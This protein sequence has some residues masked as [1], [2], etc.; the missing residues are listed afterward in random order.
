M[1]NRIKRRKWLLVGLLVVV[2]VLVGGYFLAQSKQ[3]VVEVSAVDVSVQKVSQSVSASGL[4]KAV[5]DADLSFPTVGNLVALNVAEG[6]KV[7]KNQTVAQLYNTALNQSI[8]AA[9]ESLD[10]AKKDLELYRENYETNQDAVGGMD[11]YAVAIE[12]LNEIIEQKEAMYKSEAATLRNTFLIAPFAGTV[13]D[14]PVAQ[15][16]SAIGGVTVV[17]I[18]NLDNLVFEL[19]L[20]QEDFGLVRAGMSAEV[21]LDAYEDIVFTG[22]VTGLPFFADA[23]TEEFIVQ[24]ELTPQAGYPILLGMTGDA[25]ILIAE[26]DTEV[27]AVSFDV[28]FS[29]DAGEYVWTLENEVLVKTYVETGLSGDIYTEIKTDLTGKQVVVPLGD[30]EIVE[31]SKAVLK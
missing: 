24:I 23:T 25:R 26:T 1:L 21:T 14:T 20:D 12:R 11:E 9:K 8:G 4:V 19:G 5:E 3:G 22:T 18:A 28:L 13:I 30:D 15:G 7:V 31:G 27:S 29:D 16:E 10:I 6:D 2:V 17:R